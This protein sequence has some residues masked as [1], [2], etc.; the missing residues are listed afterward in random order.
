MS[1]QRDTRL[2]FLIANVVRSTEYIP[3]NVAVRLWMLFVL[4]RYQL[5]ITCRAGVKLK[6]NEEL[7]ARISEECA[8]NIAAFHQGC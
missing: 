3:K 2:F 8:H 7:E 6:G 5:F 1:V 4:Q